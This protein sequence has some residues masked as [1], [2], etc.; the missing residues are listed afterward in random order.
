M[1]PRSPFFSDSTDA[2]DKALHRQRSAAKLS[3]SSNIVLVIVKVVAGVAS[4]AISVLAEGVQSGLDVLA[5]LMILWTVQRA[6]SPP[7]D[8]HP[9]GHGKMESMASLIQIFLICGS[10]LYILLAAWHRLKSPAMPRVDWG[11]LALSLAI[12]VNFFVARHLKT[13]ARETGSQAI[14][15]EA[16]H[17]QS[18]MISCAGVLL[19][20][21]A[22]WL[23]KEPRLDPLIAGL[24]AFV[25][26]GSSLKLARETV[27]PLLDEKLPGEEEAQ[28][29]A[30][31]DADPRVLSYHRLRTR[32]A[33][34]YRL[35]DVH[36]LLD[37]DLSFRE[38][39]A[40]V[41]EV[42]DAIRRVLPNLDI[43]VHAEPFEEEMRHQQEAH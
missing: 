40:I 34:S 27:R 42:E 17:L 13:V 6:A 8:D 32:Q 30:V 21:G 9:Y 16:V 3:L 25:V 7:D 24:M 35:M 36:L 4:G 28:I 11:A 15:A 38:S 14:A 26:I 19:G 33:G 31:L 39:H 37:D 12:I 41:E 20:L 23:T 2:R 29:V 18:D 43:I 22:V 1:T 5:S 10:A